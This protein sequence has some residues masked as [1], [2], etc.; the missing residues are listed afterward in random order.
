MKAII[1]AAGCGSRLGDITNN[2]PKC[3]LPFG[4][5][6]LIDHQI[7]NIRQFQINEVVLVVGF[8]SVEL[9]R[10]VQKYTDIT[11][12]FIENPDYAATNTAFS[13][14]LA[15]REMN[16]DFIYMNADVLFHPEIIR[17]LSHTTYDNALAV[18][19]KPLSSEE[20]KVAVDGA[21]ITNI[22]KGL[23]VALSYGEFIGVAKFSHTISQSFTA[24]LQ[25][26]ISTQRG[27]N[28]YFEDALHHITQEHFLS[29]VDVT[30]LPC[31]EIDF[32][33]DLVEAREN[34]L[35]EIKKNFPRILFYV[36]RNLHLP[37]LEPIHDYIAD[38]YNAE[39]AFY[40]P[41]YIPARVSAP[42]IGLDPGDI[43]R[44]KEKS[45]FCSSVDTF[46]PDVTVVA[47]DIYGMLDGRS[48]V[49]NVG[50]GLIS[51]GFYYKDS[52]IV[53]RCNLA[54]VICVPSAW[55]RGQLEKNITS[56]IRVT[57]FIKMD[58]VLNC[59]EKKRKTFYRTYDVPDSARLVLFAPTFNE[60]LSAIPCVGKKIA[61]C[62]TDNTFLL[63]KLHGMTDRQWVAMYQELALEKEN[64]RFIDEK[65]T[66]E[67]MACAHVMV[68]DV[69]SI[70]VEFLILDKPVVLFNNPRRKEYAFYDPQDIEY[71]LRD[72]TKEVDTIDDLKKAVVKA[73][74]DPGEKSEKRRS[75]AEMINYRLD[76]RC[77]ERAAESVMQLIGQK[78]TVRE[79]HVVYSIIVLWGHS[80]DTDTMSRI[81]KDIRQKNNG[82]NFE[83]LFLAPKTLEESSLPA[84]VKSIFYN[85]EICGSSINQAL[86][87]AAGDFVAL[88]R[89]GIVLPKSWLRWL[90]HY[91]KWHGD[92]GA[93][94]PL[95]TRDNYQSILD[96]MPSEKVPAD[97]P[98]VA[99]YFMYSLMGNDCQAEHLD[100]DCVLLSKRA[101]VD[102]GGMKDEYALAEALADFSIQLKKRAYTLWRAMEV[103]AYHEDE[104]AEHAPMVSGPVHVRKPRYEESDTG[105]KEKNVPDSASL[106]RSKEERSS[107]QQNGSDST[108]ELID[109][110]RKKRESG[111]YSHAIALLEQAKA[112]GQADRNFSGVENLEEANVLLQKSKEYKQNNDFEKSIALLEEA[113]KYAA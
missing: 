12:T 57:G 75:Y 46:S 14:W 91:F 49:V 85:R 23:P 95:T 2:L 34:K 61:D 89:P 58:A 8:Q 56:S 70:F 110:A 108:T 27:K 25:D 92:A 50:H 96:K 72:A 84:G 4:S 82:L 18:V 66:A 54:D 104:T 99:E 15:R 87:H 102:L 29:C 98:A 65:D 32:P 22:G 16:D 1:L 69:S 64:V 7:K 59:T 33:G 44:L 45:S 37:F 24:S 88:I 93:V 9:R 10:Y 94:K 77:A 21:R 68:S 103:F 42:G 76:G 35:P 51:K 109:Q 60:E 80:A 11:F 111:D 36:A 81:I 5:Q 28:A 52:P 17:R 38:N 31:I 71:K 19:R 78:N 43:K 86:L 55:H 90:S 105:F 47:E 41:P 79:D 40:S 106:C 74:N 3:L 53:R 62:A 20:V 97:L 67:A 63:I 83:I 39:L 112:M 107:L 30:D 113:K 48:K 100:D 73:I 6:R 13:L 26:M 101:F